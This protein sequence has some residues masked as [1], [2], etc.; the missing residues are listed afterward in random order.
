MVQLED[1]LQ[2]MEADIKQLQQATHVPIFPPEVQRQLPSPSVPVPATDNGSDMS[3]EPS[4]HVDQNTAEVEE[5]DIAE[6]S[7]DG[8]GAM[9]FAD[10]EDC[11]YFGGSDWRMNEYGTHT[12]IRYGRSVIKHCVCA[13]HI[14]CGG[15]RPCAQ[16]RPCLSIIAR[17]CRL[18][19][20]VPAPSCPREAESCYAQC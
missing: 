1:R 14:I 8:M 20:C 13:S 9:Q 17:H 10:E 3:M 5:V 16:I 19:E 15:S 4:R 6:D 12:D 18:Y 11:G 2:H 7:I